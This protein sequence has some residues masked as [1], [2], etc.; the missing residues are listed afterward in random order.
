MNEKQWETIETFVAIFKPTL[1]FLPIGILCYYLF[2]IDWFLWTWGILQVGWIMTIL[3]G[4][5][6]FKNR[7]K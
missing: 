2:N 5:L 1:I 3:G 7:V 4:Y 6:H